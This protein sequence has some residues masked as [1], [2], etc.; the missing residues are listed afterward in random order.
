MIG[1]SL[2]LCYPQ[3]GI[4][5]LLYPRA[6]CTVCLLTKHIRLGVRTALSSSLR[7]LELVP[8]KWRY[9]VPPTSG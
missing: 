2:P 3:I 9:L 8:A 1:S 7:G 4:S 6:L 5:H